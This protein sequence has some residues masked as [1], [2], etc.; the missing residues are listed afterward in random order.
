MYAS[1]KNLFANAEK[2]LTD[3]LVWGDTV[4]QTVPQIIKIITH[5]EVANG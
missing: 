2:T 3:A 4:P 5:E 1:D